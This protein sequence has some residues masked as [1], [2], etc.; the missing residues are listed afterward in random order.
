MIIHVPAHN[1]KLAPLPFLS[2]CQCQVTPPPPRSRP[3]TQFSRA[4]YHEVRREGGGGGPTPDTSWRDRRN[5]VSTHEKKHNVAPGGGGI[6]VAFG[7]KLGVEKAKGKAVAI[8]K[9]WQG[10]VCQGTATTA[11]GTSSRVGSQGEGQERSTAGWGALVHREGGGS[12]FWVR[13]STTRMQTTTRGMAPASSS[14]KARPR[15]CLQGPNHLWHIGN[16]H[17]KV[18]PAQVSHTCSCPLRP[19]ACSFFLAKHTA[20]PKEEFGSEVYQTELFCF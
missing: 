8:S 14:Q 19:L 1:G 18:N 10:K 3:L 13:I 12:A 5:T 20:W 11:T 6:Q 17:G 16:P 4:N 9:G 2:E 7:G 15:M